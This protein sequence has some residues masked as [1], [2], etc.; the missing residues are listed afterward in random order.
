MKISFFENEDYFNPAISSLWDNAIQV[1]TPKKKHIYFTM[2][3]IIS[4]TTVLLSIELINSYSMT[5][6]QLIICGI[7]LVILLFLHELCHAFC[8]MLLKKPIAGIRFFPY[9][10]GFFTKPSAYMKLDFCVLTKTERILMCSFPLIMLSIIPLILSVLFVKFRVLLLIIAIAN[11]CI[12]QF[13]II[14]IIQFAFIPRNA[15]MFIDAA[16]LIPTSDEPIIFHQI[17]LNKD[18]SSIVH[19]QYRYDKKALIEIV[20]P[21]QDCNIDKIIAEFKEE[22]K[23]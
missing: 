16:W 20:P 3:F 4:I 2:S 13:D 1:N 7:Y 10:F 8:A 5:K 11:V 17:K 18:H 19:K 12:S 22:F 15:C 23:I 9:L 21:E 6:Y 14:N